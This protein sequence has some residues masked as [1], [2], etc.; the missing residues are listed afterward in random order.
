[1]PKYQLFEYRDLIIEL[2]KH[3]LKN[4]YRGSVLG[5]IWYVLEPLILMLILIF[6]FKLVLGSTIENFE[7]WVL[8][9]IEIYRFFQ[10]GTSTAMNSVLLNAH[11]IK[12]IYFPREILPIYSSLVSLIIFLIE[13][14]ILIL[15]MVVLNVALKIT[16]LFIPILILLEFIIILGIGFFLGALNTKFRDLYVVWSLIIQ[17]LFWLSPIIYDISLVPENF[18]FIML[19]NPITPLIIGFRD[20]VLYGTLPNALHIL[21]LAIFGVICF[22]CGFLFYKRRAK[23]F[24]EEI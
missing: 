12:K 16:M 6:V 15:L 9:G 24:A 5:F 22:S 8:I 14:V 13:L 20:I 23:K 21:Y 4:K 11:L 1:M 17:V 3:E 18:Q 19:L 7:I 10:I 2:T